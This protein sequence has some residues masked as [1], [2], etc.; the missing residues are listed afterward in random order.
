MVDVLADGDEF[1][2]G[3]FEGEVDLDVVGAAA[4][5]AVDLVD[6]RVCDGVLGDVGEH[7]LKL[8]TVGGL[9][10]LAAVDELF[11]YGGAEAFGLAP[12]GFALCGDGVAL[13]FSSALGL[14]LLETRR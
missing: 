3:S 7:A 13:G 14:L 5:E 6:D 9:G 2:T 11:D 10:G 8:G 12:A 1:D 4:G